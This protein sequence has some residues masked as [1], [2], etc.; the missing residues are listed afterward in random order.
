[1]VPKSTINK[2]QGR[3]QTSVLDQGKYFPNKSRLPLK[4]RQHLSKSQAKKSDMKILNIF[5]HVK[6]FF[7][8]VMLR[9]V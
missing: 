5:S 4:G 1:M 7:V 9:E 2:A 8:A 6:G 3:I